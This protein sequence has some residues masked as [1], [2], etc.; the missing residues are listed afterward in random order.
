MKIWALLLTTTLLLF[1]CN[2]TKQNSQAP[3]INWTQLDEPPLFLDCP[4]DDVKLN[5]DCFTKTLEKKLQSKWATNK[6]SFG[7]LN[8]TLYV[9]LKVDTLGQISVLNYKNSAKPQT[10]MDIFYAIEE[11]IASLPLLQPAFKTNLEVPV[12]AKWILP[13]AISK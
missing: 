8:D 7:N 1:A 11:V 5:W 6:L 4:T 10:S 12:E 3:N 13:V 9:T 2:F